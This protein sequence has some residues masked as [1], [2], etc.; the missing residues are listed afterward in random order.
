MVCLVLMFLIVNSP[1]GRVF[2]GI[3]DNPDR[4]EAVG[5]N[6]MGHQLLGL[7][8]AGF[9]GGVAGTLFVTVEGSVFPDMMFWT[10][11][12]EILIMCLLGGWFTFLGPML[13]AGHHRDPAH[14]GGNLH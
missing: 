8:I 2:Q 4:A 14:R 5:V 6:V 13:G 11:S 12:L 10:L 1:F 7:V 3:R 9:F